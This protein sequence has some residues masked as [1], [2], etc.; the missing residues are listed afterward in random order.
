ML[1]PWRTG[2]INLKIKECRQ[3][4][5]TQRFHLENTSNVFKNITIIGHLEF[6]LICLMFNIFFC[7]REIS[8]NDE[9]VQ[10]CVEDYFGV[11]SSILSEKR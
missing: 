8:S 7:H 3:T 6:V 10:S 11:L 5:Q 4:L 1:S 9:Q 2:K